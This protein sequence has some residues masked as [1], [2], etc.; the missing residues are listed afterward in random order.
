MKG[1][2]IAITKFIKRNSVPWFWGWVMR[3]AYMYT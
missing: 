2:R 1:K 3:K